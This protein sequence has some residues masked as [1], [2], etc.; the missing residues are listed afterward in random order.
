ML[1]EFLSLLG[2][3][4]SEIKAKRLVI[5][6]ITALTTIIGAEKA[7][8]FLH[9][10]L[11]SL[12]KPQG[13]VTYLIADLPR[14]MET[15]GYGFEE[16]LADVVLKLT[17]EKMAGLVRRRLVIYKAREAPTSYYEYEYI[18]T[19]GG[20]KVYTKAPRSIEGTYN[21]ER[22]ETG[23]EGLDEMLNG[24]LLKA[25]STLVTG[26][27]GS[28][29]T[30]LLLSI[31]LYNASKGRKTLF[32]SY[33]ES[34]EQITT[35]AKMLGYNVDYLKNKGLFQA[36]SIGPGT[37]TPEG[38]YNIIEDLLESIK[39]QLFISD[40][41]SALER[42]YG[43]EEFVYLARNILTAAKRRGI[44]SIYSMLHDVMLGE[45]AYV[46]TISDTLIALWLDRSGDMIS[47][48]IAVLKMRGSR[49]DRSKRKL[50]LGNKKVVVS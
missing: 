1:S 46:S 16:F 31:A 45:I 17:M 5:D 4:I 49:H 44:T 42:F 21:V 48:R 47:R 40:G 22:L 7:R 15:I 2:E 29:K 11:F 34:A 12:T 9:S 20:I 33:E 10:T 41:V 23:V 43:E 19:K 39:P 13:I 27:S 8:A 18:I 25:S 30:M 14:G 32:I 38:L 35:A 50:I 36:V 24:G 37:L 26:P 3:K 28:G 6:P